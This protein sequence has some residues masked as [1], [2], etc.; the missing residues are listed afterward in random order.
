MLTTLEQGLGGCGS[1]VES[2]L[3]NTNTKQVL[4]AEMHVTL[5]ST[6]SPR[7]KNTEKLRGNSQE[8]KEHIDHHQSSRQ[9]E[10]M[11]LN[12]QGGQR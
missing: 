8:S 2:V 9:R 7:L 3:P 1:R 6:I 5:A 11:A 10:R 12:I 4:H